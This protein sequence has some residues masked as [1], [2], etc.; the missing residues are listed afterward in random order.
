MPIPKQK[1]SFA[2]FRVRKE[3]DLMDKQI[4]NIRYGLTKLRK[5]G[6]KDSWSL[7]ERKQAVSTLAG[8]EKELQTLRKR[9]GLA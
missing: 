3:D 4:Y 5:L 9:C 6:K 7:E 1:I 8:M 2:K